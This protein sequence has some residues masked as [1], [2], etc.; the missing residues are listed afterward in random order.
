MPDGS[1]SAAPVTI[2][3]PSADS[4]CRIGV[5][6]SRLICSVITHL[7][8]RPRTA[9]RNAH[10]DAKKGRQDIA[11]FRSVHR[12]DRNE[13]SGGSAAP[14]MVHEH[15]EVSAGGRLGGTTTSGFAHSSSFARHYTLR[16][17]RTI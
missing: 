15:A 14:A 8:H 11:A 7:R 3:G 5:S 1:S 2:P 17:T 10:Y 9:G 12:R 13:R 4:N 6:S 16:H